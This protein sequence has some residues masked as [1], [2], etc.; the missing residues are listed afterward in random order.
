MRFS[1]S[2][3]TTYT[4]SDEV[5]LQPHKIRL[6]PRSDPGQVLREYSIHFT[7]E[8]EGTTDALDAWGNHV[9]W[10]WFSGRTSKLEI[11]TRFVVD[12]LR[13]NPF[14]F[15]IPTPEG[16]AIPPAYAQ[17]ERAALGPYFSSEPGPGVVRLADAVAEAAGG[18]VLDFASTLAE[19]LH[20]ECRMI[21]RPTGSPMRG[22]DTLE[23]KEGSCRDLAVLYIEAC[24]HVGIAARF[25]SGYV[26]RH[27]F[28]APRE[29]H[30]WAGVYVPG[31]GWRGF[32]P[33][34]GLAVAN[35]HV[36]LATAGQPAGAAPVTGSFV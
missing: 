13:A 35:R 7:P 11:I 25:V 19:R 14:D 30:A 29:L 23:Q 21:V 10:A 15:V 26:E 34:Q 2:H 1:G 6:R 8:P 31:A 32:D 3:R 20:E 27:P 28:D 18:R 4:Y 16:E 5:F 17:D 12:R 22:E 33:S 36:T 24:R 9:T